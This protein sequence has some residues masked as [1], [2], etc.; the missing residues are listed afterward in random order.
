MELLNKDY[1]KGFLKIR[2]DTNEDL[3]FLNRLLKEGDEVRA[4][5]YRKIKKGSKETSVKKKVTVTIQTEKTEFKEEPFSLRVNGKIT[6]SSDEDI[7][8]GSYHS[9]TLEE[10]ETIIINKKISATDKK[11]LEKA[12]QKT[13]NKKI[14]LSVIDYGESYFGLL[15]RNK[16]KLLG[17]F[18][19]TLGVKEL[20]ES[21]SNRETYLK[22]YLEKLE[23]HM[24]NNKAD[25]A[26]IGGIGFVTDNLKNVLPNSLKDKIRFAK[27]S[28]NTERGLHELVKRGE[29][30]KITKNEEIT[31]ET[32]LVEE[33]FEK[34][35]KGSK[36]LTYGLKNVKEKAE[37]GAVTLLLI[38]D[39]MLLKGEVNEI[40]EQ[41]EKNGGKVEIINSEHAMGEE[42]Q[43]FGGIAAYLRY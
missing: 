3:F 36:K 17:S 27:V 37:S 21:E 14:I 18:E 25:L 2:V 26:L 20:K 16:I 40:I 24:K 35:N 7:P 11:I 6:E 30:E 23:N 8:L 42:F 12:V 31:K 19:R 4:G 5:T 13:D 1:R 28:T 43:N 33:F 34:L 32:K 38:T 41:T 10:G 39:K 9:L 22:E 29:V 15:M